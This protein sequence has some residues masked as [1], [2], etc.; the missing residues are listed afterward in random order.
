MSL[1]EVQDR[2]EH[3]RR[4]SYCYESDISDITADGRKVAESCIRSHSALI[5]QNTMTN[6]ETTCK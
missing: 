4:Y 2:S 5:E 6:I 3:Q 1:V